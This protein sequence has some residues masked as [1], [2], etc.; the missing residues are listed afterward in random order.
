MSTTLLLQ[1]RQGRNN[2]VSGKQGEGRR[3]EVLF[4]FVSFVF[5]KSIDDFTQHETLATLHD[6]EN[7]P[8]AEY[9]FPRFLSFDNKIIK[10]SSTGVAS[11]SFVLQRVNRT[12]FSQKQ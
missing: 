12:Q 10:L 8:S 11:N 2:V 4:C 9:F 1:I 3:R 5:F 6:N 7:L